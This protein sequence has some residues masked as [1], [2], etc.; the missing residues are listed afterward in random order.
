MI[1]VG[2]RE[3]VMKGQNLGKYRVWIQDFFKSGSGFRVKMWVIIKITFR[4]KDI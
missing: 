2:L 4:I 3:R 1:K